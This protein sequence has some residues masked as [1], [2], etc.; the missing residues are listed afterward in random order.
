MFI[1]PPVPNRGASR[2]AAQSA[3]AVLQRRTRASGFTLLEV[4]VALGLITLVIGGVY[5]V[6]EG[7]IKLSA[8]MNK[9][10]VVEVRVSNF[11][12]Q[13]R[14]YL[15]NVPPTI[16]LSCGLER[17]ARGAAGNLLIEGGQ[18]PFVWTPA[19]KLADAVEFAVV[20]SEGKKALSLVV[21]HLKRLEKPTA[22]DSY[23]TLAELPILEGLKE[24]KTQFYEPV[25]ER[26]FSSWDPKKHPQPPLF[27]RMQFTLME[28]PREHDLT[29][30]IANDLKPAEASSPPERATL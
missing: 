18:A 5:G 4:I 6:A 30:W 27:M 8:S 16:R 19:L 11:A 29:F 23:A 15:E 14:D 1:H 25:E 26:W 22:M 9:A 17:G 3:A 13:W 7:S 21:R 24:F 2:L 12:S 10:R 20:R 28:D